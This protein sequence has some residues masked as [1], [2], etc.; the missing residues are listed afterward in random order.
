MKAAVFGC[1]APPAGS[2]ILQEG[3]PQK[4][5]HAH[6]ALREALPWSPSWRK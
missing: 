5:L 1:V 2:G 3:L 6:P 4:V